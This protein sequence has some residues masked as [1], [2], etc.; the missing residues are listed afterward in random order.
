MSSTTLQIPTAR[1]FAPL[2][3]PARYK[4]AHGGRGSG[5]SHFFAGLAVEQCLL[6]PG[7]RV[8]CVREVQKSL[9][10]SVKL[11]IEDKIREF[12]LAQLFEIMEAEIR[13]PG[14]GVIIFQG[15]QNHTADSIKSLEGF[16]VAWVEEAQS[17]SRRSLDLLRPTIRKPGSELW[18]SWNPNEPDDPVDALLRG[19]QPP[20]GAV[21]VE[22]NWSDNP[23]LP[24]E[25]RQDL[26]DDR[27]RDPDKFAHVWGGAYARNSEA[28]VFRNW[29]V[30]AFDTP[31]DAIHRYG[32]DWG[33]AVDPSVL[34]RCR[35]EGRTLYVDQE[36]WQVGCEID[37][38][39]ALF[40]QVEGSR[41]WPIRADSARPETVSYMRRNGFP[42]I[43]SA[44]KGQGSLED[45][46]EFLRSFDIVVHPRCVHVAEELTRYSYKTDPQTGEILPLL[47][48]KDNHTIDAL[49]Y[50]LE[51][52]RRSG[53]KPSANAPR[54]RKRSDYGFNV[55]PV[56]N[57][58]TA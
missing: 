1:V 3:H 46:I 40:D 22:A 18:F 55:E 26:E 43:T 32:A 8:A 12:G 37:H 4:G 50:A 31:A 24:A 54:E 28:R 48:D 19:D 45:G 13:T 57:W 53:Y 10:N 33:F 42:R 49:R 17:L 39:P 35:V 2:L 51:E 36:A 41:R 34:V 38:L 7:C 14:D 9:K 5:K 20:A 25:L 44:I 29:T 27:R 6:Q 11:L 16:D 47:A 56:R 58:K 15:M 30:E 52:L 21:V 23:W